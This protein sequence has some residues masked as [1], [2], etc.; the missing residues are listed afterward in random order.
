M[1]TKIYHISVN[2]MKIANNWCSER[3]SREYYSLFEAK[4]ACSLDNGCSL[5]YDSYCDGPPY[6]LCRSIPL[7]S[8]SRSCLYR[9]P[10]EQGNIF[11]GFYQS[12]FWRFK[13]LC[14]FAV[15]IFDNNLFSVSN[16][17]CGKHLA[18]SCYECPQGYGEIWC[19]GDCRWDSSKCVPRGTH[20]SIVPSK[21]KVIHNKYL[22]N[23]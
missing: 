10:E 16:V 4:K 12:K 5:I 18:I 2:Y 13:S 7:H 6:S 14:Y 17:N 9:K 20:S 23:E 19:N 15:F 1:S 11:I 22:H 8:S 3:E 21:K